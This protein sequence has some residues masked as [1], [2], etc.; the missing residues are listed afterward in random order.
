LNSKNQKEQDN[1][2]Q[3]LLPDSS[4]VLFSNSSENT[5]GEEKNSGALRKNY[6]EFG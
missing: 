6:Q 5:I 1:Y 2:I 3:L 4:S